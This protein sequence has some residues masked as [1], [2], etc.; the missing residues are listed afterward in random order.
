M[1]NLGITLALLCLVAVGV[2]ASDTHDF[3]NPTEGTQPVALTGGDIIRA[4]VVVGTTNGILIR[5]AVT[6]R[7]R[8]RLCIEN[9]AAVNIQIGPSLV[10]G[11]ANFYIGTNNTTYPNIFCTNSSAAFYG[12]TTSGTGNIYAIEETQ[13][14]P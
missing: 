4:Y 2:W 1:R 8:R 13:S 14:I 9:G 11:S 12:F 7:S 6:D 3:L 5:S 10:V